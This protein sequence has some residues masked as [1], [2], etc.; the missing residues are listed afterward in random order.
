MAELGLKHFG[1][2]MIALA[3]L[4]ILGG[5]AVMYVGLTHTVEDW[6]EKAGPVPSLEPRHDALSI[7]YAMAILFWAYIG[8]T[9]ITQSGSELKEAKKN[10]PRALIL[11]TAL[12]T[13][14]YFMYSYAFYHAVPWQAMV[15]GGSVPELIKVFVPASLSFLLTLFVLLA[16]T[17]DIPSMLYTGSRL[18]YRWAK[19]GIAPAFLA[20]VNE[21]GSPQHALT[22]VALLAWLIA[23]FSA[24]G[25]LFTEVDVVVFSRFLLYALVALSLLLLPTSNPAAYRR[26]SF[27]RKRP[28]QVVLAGIVIAVALV[29][30]GVIFMEEIETPIAVNPVVQT[31]FFLA[32]GYGLYRKKVLKTPQEM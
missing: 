26:I 17:N 23:V 15:E 7:I 28:L 19:D 16:L 32:I 18:L 21:R 11:T 27:L 31:A 4:M 25:G 6:V 9:S 5:T 8:F 13:L 20:K 29:F 10:L 22:A 1:K 3:L 12:V 14:Y 30:G 24:F 2:G